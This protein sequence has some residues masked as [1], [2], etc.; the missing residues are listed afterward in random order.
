VNL[1]LRLLLVLLAVYCA[2]GWYLTRRALEQVGAEIRFLPYLPG[3]ST[4]NLIAK[5]KA[6]GEV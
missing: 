6:A 3:F 5:I 4:T 2:G 1:R